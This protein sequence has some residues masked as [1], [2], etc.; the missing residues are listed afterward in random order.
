MLL[1][2]RGGFFAG[3]VIAVGGV[4]GIEGND[5]GLAQWSDGADEDSL[6]ALP[7]A[8]LAG[9][10]RGNGL[11]LLAAEELQTLPKVLLADDVE[12]RRL[13]QLHPQGLVQGGV[14]NRVA[15]FVDKVGDND[16]VFSSRRRRLGA[17]MIAEQKNSTAQGREH[18]GADDE[19]AGAER[20]TACRQR[21]RGRRGWRGV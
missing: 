8:D 2:W 20:A 6:A 11:V 3:N 10:L 4:L 18:Q 19:H 17:G 9:N 13:A 1:V 21:R 5:I 14:K 16:A 15:G 12:H 7:L